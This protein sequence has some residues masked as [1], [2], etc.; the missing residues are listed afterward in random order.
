MAS[1]KHLCRV[2]WAGCFQRW[3][4]HRGIRQGWSEG[5]ALS[6]KREGARL[7]PQRIPHLWNAAGKGTERR[8]EAGVGTA[9]SANLQGT[10]P[11]PELRP[12][13]TDRQTWR[14]GRILVR[15]SDRG[16]HQAAEQV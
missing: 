2:G 12:G 11:A 14:L 13:G 6:C 3:E 16:S 15:E 5:E 7:L 8:R 10:L 4:G 9:A 1:C